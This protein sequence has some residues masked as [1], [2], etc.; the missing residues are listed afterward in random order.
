LTGIVSLGGMSGKVPV[1]LQSCTT[2]ENPM[3]IKLY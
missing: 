1:R 2:G 3:A